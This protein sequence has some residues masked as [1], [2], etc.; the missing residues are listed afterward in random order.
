MAQPTVRRARQTWTQGATGGNLS[1]RRPGYPICPAGRIRTRNAIRNVILANR[2]HFAIFA[3]AVRNRLGLSWN[4]RAD[5]ERICR[6]AA[7]QAHSRD[8]TD[9]GLGCG[10]SR[11]AATPE[12]L[13]RR[14]RAEFGRKRP[15]GRA[16]DR[17]A[18]GSGA[19]LPATPP[20]VRSSPGSRCATMR[21]GHAGSGPS[22][23]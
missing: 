23:D 3:G 22:A 1:L 18:L 15:A 4:P 17:D 7:G 21:T 12:A 8:R 16:H 5:G 11:I 19:A 13:R 2:G 9:N 6:I 20:S 10:G 14:W